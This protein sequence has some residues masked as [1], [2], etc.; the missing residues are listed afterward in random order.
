MESTHLKKHLEELSVSVSVAAHVKVPSHWK[1]HNHV[2]VNNCLYYFREGEGTL[3]IRDSVFL[4]KPGDL[5]VLPAGDRISFSTVPEA[6]FRLMYCHFQAMSGRFPLFQVVDTPLFIRLQDQD[7]AEELFGRLIQNVKRTDDL[8]PLAVK[9][10][11]FELL[12]FMWE[13]ESRKPVPILSSSMQRWNDI[14]HFMEQHSDR[15]LTVTEIAEKFNYSTKYFIR[16]FKAAFGVP[17]H[18][19]LVKLRMERGKQLL[20]STEW[21]VTRVADELGMERSHFTRLFQGKPT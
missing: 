17:P 8:S 3:H 2:T 11:M 20:H 12:V 19:Y 7:R 5:Y 4:P 21:T 10:A 6:P 16:L 1:H 9:S 15:A 13:Q 14:V 18:R